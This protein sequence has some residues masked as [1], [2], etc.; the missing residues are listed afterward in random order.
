M[1]TVEWNYSEWA[2]SHHWVEG[3]EEWSIAWGG[4]EAQWFG[5]L[6]PRLHRLL[7]AGTILEIAPGYGRWTKF[8]IAQC[9]QYI[10]VDLSPNCIEACQRRFASVPHARFFSNDGR[11]LDNVPD[12]GVDLIFSFDSLVH[13]E[14]DVF[15]AYVPAILRKLTAFGVAFLHHSNMA[16]L[17]TEADAH[18]RATSVSGDRI[19]EIVNASGGKILMQEYINWG[20]NVLND[21]LTLLARAD[22]YSDVA[23]TVLT[24]MRFMDEAALISQYQAPYSQLKVRNT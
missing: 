11:S 3:G 12:D 5:S 20:G 2:K 23:P 4:S 6:Y 24:N 21:C 16:A 10:G 17:G 7:P 9:N 22:A 14:I 13:A 8:L 19:A 15:V 18:S 1:L